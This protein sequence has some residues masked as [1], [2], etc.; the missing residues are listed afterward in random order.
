MDW[1]LEKLFYL[2]EGLFVSIQYFHSPLVADFIAPKCQVIVYLLVVTENGVQGWVDILLGDSVPVNSV[3]AS[4]IR[5][6]NQLTFPKFQSAWTALRIFTNQAMHPLIM[7][8]ASV[9][10]FH[11]YLLYLDTL[12]A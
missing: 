3:N 9:S 10:H 2:V 8:F 5:A 6:V 4:M 1:N 7:I 11:V 12:L